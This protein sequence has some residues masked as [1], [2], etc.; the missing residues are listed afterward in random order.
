MENNIGI[1]NSMFCVRRMNIKILLFFRKH[2]FL[3]NEVN[4]RIKKLQFFYFIIKISGQRKRLHNSF[5]FNFFLQN[6]L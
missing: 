1:L 4:E 3:L 5:D 2:F 6:I